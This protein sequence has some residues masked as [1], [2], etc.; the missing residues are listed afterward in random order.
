MYHGEAICVISFY[1]NIW[2][3]VSLQVVEV[4]DWEH[5]SSR[6]FAIKNLLDKLRTHIAGHKSIATSFVYN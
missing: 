6:R 4:Y 3:V 5:C 1:Y 2:L